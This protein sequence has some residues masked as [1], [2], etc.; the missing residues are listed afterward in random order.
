[1]K[2][3]Q[4]EPLAGLIITTVKAADVKGEQWDHEVD[5]RVKYIFGITSPT[6][7]KLHDHKQLLSQSP[8]KTSIILSHP[9][10]PVTSFPPTQPLGESM[11]AAEFNKSRTASPPS[12]LF[13]DEDL[14]SS[15]PTP[16]LPSSPIRGNEE[17]DAPMPPSSQKRPRHDSLDEDGLDADQPFQNWGGMRADGFLPYSW[18]SAAGDGDVRGVGNI[19]DARRRR[20]Q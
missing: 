7:S 20:L 4:S 19:S 1:M 3:K 10:S 9:S 5:T 2:K 11:L 13:R 8:P 12:D 14:G 15:P 18:R 17:N 16:P 6:R